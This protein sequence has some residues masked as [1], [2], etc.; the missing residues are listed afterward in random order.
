MQL[1]NHLDTPYHGDRFLSCQLLTTVDLI[2]LQPALGERIPR[3][4]VQAI[5]RVFLKLSSDKKTAGSTIANVA[6]ERQFYVEAPGTFD[7]GE[8]AMNTL[9]QTYSGNALN[10]TRPSWA[11]GKW[12]GA[13]YKHRRVIPEWLKGVEGCF[14]VARIIENLTNPCLQKLVP[15]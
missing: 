14:Y 10:N 11:K 1:Q 13:R 15:P 3:S 6:E 4:I 8:E 7:D 9:G 12:F 2:N 5:N